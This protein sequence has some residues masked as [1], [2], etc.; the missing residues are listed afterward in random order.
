MVLVFASKQ[1]KH[2]DPCNCK[3]CYVSLSWLS[4]LHLVSKGSVA[5]SKAMVQIFVRSGGQDSWEIK[6]VL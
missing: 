2:E 4:L 3:Y 6:K 1:G 5:L